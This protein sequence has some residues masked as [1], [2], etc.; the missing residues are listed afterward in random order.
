V[1]EGRR[2]SNAALP[3]MLQMEENRRRSIKMKLD[4]STALKSPGGGEKT[5]FA[6]AFCCCQL[7]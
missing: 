4:V 2:T 7:A 3:A 1:W 5:L 6:G